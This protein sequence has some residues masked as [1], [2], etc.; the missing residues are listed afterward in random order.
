MPGISRF[1]AE[2]IADKWTML[3]LKLGRGVLRRVAVGG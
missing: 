1:T 3:G 2:Q